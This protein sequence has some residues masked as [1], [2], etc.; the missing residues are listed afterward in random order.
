MIMPIPHRIS[1]I[2]SVRGFCMIA[3]LYFHTEIYYTNTTIIPY[4]M[5]VVNALVMFFFISGFL[6]YKENNFHIKKKIKSIF[7]SLIKPYFI[8]TAI[9]SIPKT[10]VHGENIEMI[11]IIK[12]ILLGHAS[13]FI[14]ALIIAEFIFSIILYVSKEKTSII[15]VS[16]CILFCIGLSFNHT[17]LLIPWHAHIAALSVLFIASGYLYH[18]FNHLFC[19][20]TNSFTF[21]LALVV[22]VICKII[23]NYYELNMIIY[24]L[25]IDNV[26]IFLIDTFLSIYIIIYL[27]KK[28]PQFHFIQYVGRHCIVFYFL[29]GGIPLLTSKVFNA[30]SLGYSSNYLQLL[31]V[32][33]CVLV[34]TTFI[35]WIIY[36]YIKIV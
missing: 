10:M 31:P 7:R 11:N 33:F 14:A 8:F 30:I 15:I 3:I 2:D 18:R 20:Y 25:N 5:Y 27:A 24:V 29:C 32:F 26:F 1:W 9:I 16:S 34:I 4:S 12:Q 19:H 35:T 28:L 21:V 36:K 13:W 17:D 23:E 22:L 6:F